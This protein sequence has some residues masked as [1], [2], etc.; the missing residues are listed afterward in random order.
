[1]KKKVI[2]AIE[3]GKTQVAAVEKNPDMDK[4]SMNIY[5]T[6]IGT[7]A[8]SITKPQLVET[9]DSELQQDQEQEKKK[10]PEVHMRP[11]E[12]FEKN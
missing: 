10:E 11:E 4:E 6:E 1:M 9:L 3:K 8:I 7:G 12:Y 5:G 2:Q